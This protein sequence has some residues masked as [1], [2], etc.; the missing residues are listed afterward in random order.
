MVGKAVLGPQAF[1][2]S[3]STDLL[4]HLCHLALKGSPFLAF[5]HGGEEIPGHSVS[6]LLSWL[7]SVDPP[8]SLPSCHR[9]T[10]AA[11]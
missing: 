6:W 2:N 3:Q 7:N 11:L 4:L 1:C 8:I 10:K 9:G 5:N